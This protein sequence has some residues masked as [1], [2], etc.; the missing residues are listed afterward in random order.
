MVINPALS[1]L[2]LIYRL[3]TRKNKN[4]HMTH[5]HTL[6]QQLKRKQARVLACLLVLVVFT[7]LFAT[8]L[9]A[10][11]VSLLD[12][13][14]LLQHSSQS[15]NSQADLSNNVLWQI[16]LN[17][18]LPRILLA[19]LI[20]GAL[21]IAGAVLQGLFR[22]PLADPGL[23]GISSGAAL[24][25][26]L[27]ILLLPLVSQLSVFSEL[28]TSANQSAIQSA[29]LLQ[30]I[31]YWF[32]QY[33]I[34]FAAFLGGLLVSLMLFFFA[35]HK[36]SSLVKLLLLGIA[37]NAISGGAI[38]LFSYLS[39][40]AQLRQFMLW[41][42]GSLGTANWRTVAISTSIILPVSALLFCYAKKIN[43]L[44]LGYEQAFYLGV[45]VKRTQ[46][47]L[48]MLCAILVGIAVAF[49]GVI[50]FVG[51]VVPHLLR[52]QFGA[53]HRFLLPACFLAGGGFL[54]LSDSVARLIIIPAEMPVGIITSLIGGPYF[55]YL[56]L[57][58]KA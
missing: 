33:S 37:I 38:G 19:L 54:L 25:V 52:M 29:N 55:L 58:I 3:I 40:D 14:H 44:Q 15:N 4:I 32:Y 11:R 28:S 57:K 45:D 7:A 43:L 8:Q 30:T 39:N 50:G 53:D 36:Q 41:T 23:L 35:R 24:T 21:A 6:S 46:W 49:T 20:G 1:I 51:L 26:A 31:T 34:V 13:W 5:S 18:R 10:V 27:T 9:G 2:I 56:I 42:M 12:I 22:N 47:Q 17:I 48:L 16:W